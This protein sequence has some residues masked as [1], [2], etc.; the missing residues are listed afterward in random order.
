MS[1]SAK[2]TKVKAK[3]GP[4]P[5]RRAVR[6]GPSRRPPLDRRLDGG[7]SSSRAATGEIL[8]VIRQLADRRCS[9]CST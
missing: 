9:P 3:G 6:K 4:P 7:R 5:G 1:R 8:R 2:P